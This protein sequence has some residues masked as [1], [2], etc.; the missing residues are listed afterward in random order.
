PPGRGLGSSGAS[1]AGA[2]AGAARLLGLNTPVEVLVESAGRGEAAAAG[3]PHYDNVAASLL[4]GFVVLAR[5]MDGLRVVRIDADAWF[6]VVTPMDP[7]PEN[8]TMI[9]RSVLPRQV[10]LEEA[11]SNWSRL[12]MLVAALSEGR[13]DLVGEM[14][15]GDGIVEPRRSKYIPCYSEMRREA[16]RAGAL[17]Y[18]ISG[19]GPSVIALT[20]TQSSARTVLD[21]ML[22]SCKWNTEPLGRISKV[23]PGALAHA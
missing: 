15:M 23:A 8:K 14:M 13:L 7:V 9:M 6:A 18:T 2:V 3:A 12:A 1:A 19:A 17:G 16:L 20:D 11:V 22:S 4:G 5:G 21:A 10:S